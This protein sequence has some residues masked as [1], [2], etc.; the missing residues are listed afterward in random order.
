MAKS[1]KKPAKKSVKQ[2][3]KPRRKA[4]TP[5]TKIATASR[6]ITSTLYNVSSANKA[7]LERLSRLLDLAIENSKRAGK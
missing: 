7:S 1:K 2:P 3:S 6:A 5:E 4:A